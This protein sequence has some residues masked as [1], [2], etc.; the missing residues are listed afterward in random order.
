M[1]QIKCI[2]GLFRPFLESFTERILKSVYQSLRGP[3]GGITISL[4]TAMYAGEPHWQDWFSLADAVLYRAKAG[5]HN[6][7]MIAEDP[8]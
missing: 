4:G 8:D 6:N 5:G 7:Y 1:P 3:G 2:S